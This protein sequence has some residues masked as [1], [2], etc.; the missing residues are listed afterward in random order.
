MLKVLI[1]AKLASLMRGHKK[2]AADNDWME[3][4]VRHITP[5]GQTRLVKVKSLTPEEMEKYRPK[6]LKTGFNMSIPEI[7]SSIAEYQKSGSQREFRKLYE[8]FLP[9]ILRTVRKVIGERDVSREDK[10]DLTAN[11]RMI[12]HRAIV[13]ADP[14]R[15]GIVKYIHTTLQKQLEGKSRETFRPTIKIGPKDR[16]L[17]RAVQRY[18]Y[19]FESEHGRPVTSADYEGIARAINDDPS[20]RIT[21]ATPELIEK[22]LQTGDVA[23][24]GEVGTEDDS[25]SLHEVISPDDVDSSTAEISTI[26]PPDEEVV[27]A[28]IKKVV[29]KAIESLSDPIERAA[30]KLHY[31]FGN[32]DGEHVGESLGHAQIAQIL[33]V[34]RRVV[35]RAIVKAQMRLRQLKDI[36]K[37]SKSIVRIMKAYDKHIRFAYVPKSVKKI[38]SNTYQVDNFTIRKYSNQLVCSCG[39]N[40][41][42][43]EVVKDIIAR[44]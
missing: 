24:E 3:K 15:G 7:Q 32:D 22:L 1:S 21:H 33:D 9:L 16:R 41:F 30:V 14:T 38:S 37:L 34:P 35:R 2:T 18:V 31:G 42:H 19:A 28:D 5:T 10:D 8:N 43:K 36:Q 29:Q 44:G 17:L 20:S 4:V 13:N 6:T 39:K 12:F 25:R 11:A 40:C 27:A 26:P 23:L